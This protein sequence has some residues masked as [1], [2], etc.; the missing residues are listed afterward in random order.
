MVEPSARPSFSLVTNDNKPRKKKDLIYAS[1]QKTA[2]RSFQ[3]VAWPVKGEQWALG[4]LEH[5][6]G[7]KGFLQ[8]EPVKVSLYQ[9]KTFNYR[10]MAEREVQEWGGRFFSD[11]SKNLLTEIAPGV[12]ASDKNG[13]KILL[14]Y[15][16]VA[17]LPFKLPPLV[18]HDPPKKIKTNH[19]GL[20]S[21]H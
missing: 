7:K 20:V 19:L 12:W 13:P 11:V 6:W 10:S 1:V 21:L 4:V 2:D 3:I 14:N 16:P 17:K 5:F 8:G 18:N 9:C 15:D